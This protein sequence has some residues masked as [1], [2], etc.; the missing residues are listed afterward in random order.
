MVPL[1]MSP[2]VHHV[3]LQ[4][5]RRVVLQ[6]VPH[7]GQQALVVSHLAAAV[8]WELQRL[9]VRGVVVGVPVGMTLL[10]H[11]VTPSD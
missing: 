1:G 4:G 6:G 8:G 7:A 2:T 11:P 3:V 9:F 5:V 10:C